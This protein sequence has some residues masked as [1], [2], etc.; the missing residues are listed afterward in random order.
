MCSSIMALKCYFLVLSPETVEREYRYMVHTPEVIVPAEDGILNFLEIPFQIVYTPGHSAGHIAV[1][2]PD[3][4]CY[5]GDAILSREMLNAKL[6]YELNHKAAEESRKKLK[7]LRCE[8]YIMAHRGVCDFEEMQQLIDDN[9]ELLQ[10]RAREV[11]ELIQYP[12]TFSEIN[13]QVCIFYRL[14]TKVPRRALRFERNIRFFLEYLLDQ[15]QL[16]AEC[17]NGTVLYSRAL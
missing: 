14:L 8:R 6:P 16:Q 9:Q 15:G 13:E 17:R 2:T 11:L 10:R 3:H 4:V 12:M 1:I 7:Q 5:T